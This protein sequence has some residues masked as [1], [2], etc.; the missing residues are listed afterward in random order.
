MTI[1][2]NPLP[3]ILPKRLGDSLP[4]AGDPIL[5]ISSLHA[6]WDISKPNTLYQ[7]TAGTI[8]ANVGDP[9]GLIVDRVG[10]YNLQQGTVANKPTL[11]QDTQGNYYLDFD[12]GDWLEVP[13]STGSF[14]FMHNG[15]GGEY[16]VAGRMG[17]TASPNAAYSP[18]SNSNLGSATVG[19]GLVWNDG[20]PVHELG[21]LVGNGGSIVYQLNQQNAFEGNTGTVFGNSFSTAAGAN[22]YVNGSSVLSGA[23]GNT[24]S[25]GNATYNMTVGARASVKDFLLTGRI[26]SISVYSD[27]LTN[28]QRTTVS[29]YLNRGMA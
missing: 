25:A 16:V 21:S 13:S 18:I 14:N 8:Q 23:Q 19:S 7:D 17:N 11:R 3:K 20:T 26:Y 15:T 2:A 22:L 24:P 1:L 29:D 9:V 10:G 28:A 5:G 27:I 4:E 12:G 6:Y